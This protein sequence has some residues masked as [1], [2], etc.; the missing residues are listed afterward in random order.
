LKKILISG[1]KGS[2]AQSINSNN[3]IIYKPSKEEMDIT[4]PEQLENV[5]K[6]F[7]PEYFIHAAALTRPMVEHVQN[8][9]K[10]ITTNIIGT[11]NIVNA[12]IKHKIKLIYISTDYI[13]PGNT[14][15]YV[16]EDPISP[17]NEYAW[18]KLGGECAVKLYNNFLILRVATVDTPFPHDYALGDVYKS[19]ISVKEVS[20]YI[21]ELLD[22]KGIINVGNEKLVIYDYVRKINPNIKK[23]FRKDIKDVNIAKDSSMN[24]NKL[25]SIVK[26]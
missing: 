13:Y 9:I 25:N 1:G 18:S 8:P 3:Y 23:I 15:D 17:V 2:L 6:S 12:C 4:N 11:A 16:E 22:E 14:G 24:V 21:L 26:K 7:K 10:S 5:L 19:S 20:N